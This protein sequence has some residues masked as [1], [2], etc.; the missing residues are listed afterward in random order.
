MFIYTVINVCVYMLIN[1]IVSVTR[2]PTLMYEFD[3]LSVI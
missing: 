3:Y 1:D 2:L